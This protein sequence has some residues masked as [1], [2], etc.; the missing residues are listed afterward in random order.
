[1]VVMAGLLELGVEESWPWERMD[2]LGARLG[3]GRLGRRLFR[4]NAWGLAAWALSL[5]MLVGAGVA[6]LFLAYRTTLA[7][8]M[9][10][11]ALLVSGVLVL[12]SRDEETFLQRL[13]LFVAAG[14]LLGVEIVYMK[15]FLA[16]GE[17]R[18]MNTVFKFY[19]QAW[20]LLGL[21][22]GSAWPALWQRYARGRGVGGRVWAGAFTLLLALSLVYPLLA[23]PVRVNE[24]FS[25]A[26]PPRGTLD[27]TAYMETA[28]YFWPDGDHPI[29]MKHDRAA[30]QWLWENVQGTPVLAEAPV[31]FYREGGLRVSSY[32]GLP[33]LLG[34]HER[35]QR[36]WEQVGARENDALALYT[37]ADL[38]QVREI[39]TRLRVRFVYVGPL[40]RALYAGLGL[41][42]FTTLVEQGLLARVYQNEGV[43]IY[44]VR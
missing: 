30:I 37:S 15:D 20:V 23:L 17:W 32:T 29:E 13:L 5:A 39:L 38:E 24:R 6:G 10:A 28:I 35:E 33:T 26:W 27:G 11:F 16:E 9:M 41:D 40:E 18:R 42:K 36:P 44:E 25:S 34:A 1:L 4:L 8:G 22:G 3:W 7:I 21:A 19:T 31:G 14:I 2:R 43:D 12:W